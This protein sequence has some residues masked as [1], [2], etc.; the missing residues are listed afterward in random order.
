MFSAI[1]QIKFPPKLTFNSRQFR[2]ILKSY[3]GKSKKKEET[4]AA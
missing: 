2:Q 4:E 1:R 3:Y